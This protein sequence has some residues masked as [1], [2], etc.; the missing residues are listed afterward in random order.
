MSRFILFVMLLAGGPAWSD[1]GHLAN[2]AGHGHWLAAAAAGAAVAIAI[3]AG[4]R[5]K[6][7]EPEEADAPDDEAQ[8]A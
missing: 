7:R 6:N 3:W 4:L 1:P 5:G 8:E 2:V